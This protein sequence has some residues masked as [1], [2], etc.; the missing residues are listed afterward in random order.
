[1]FF[2]IIRWLVFQTE[3]YLS[4]LRDSITKN[5]NQCWYLLN[6]WKMWVDF[7]YMGWVRIWKVITM[8][9]VCF[10]CSEFGI[11]W[12]ICCSCWDGTS[13]CF[14][15]DELYCIL[16]TSGE[17]VQTIATVWKY[18]DILFICE[19]ESE[20]MRNLMFIDHILDWF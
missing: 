4:I 19:S 5:K 10:F 20:A 15:W 18:V 7:S 8:I 14:C 2:W 3:G 1:M 6:R 13:C 12:W 16:W 17:C 11:R 9:I